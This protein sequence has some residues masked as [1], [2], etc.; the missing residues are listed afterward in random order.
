MKAPSLLFL[1]LFIANHG[2]AQIASTAGFIPAGNFNVYYQQQG[3]GP[4]VVLLHAGLQNSTMWESQITALSKTHRV[5][6]IDLP[7]HGRTKGIDTTLLA[8]EVVKIV[9]DSLGLQKLSLVGLSM[10]ASVAQD[11]VI[12]Y[13]GRV[14]KL[15]LL[16]SGINGYERHFPIDSASTVWYIRYAKAME[17]KD[18]V[19]AAKEFALAWGEGIHHK[20]ELTKRAAQNVYRTTLQTLRT[21]PPGWPKLQMAPPAYEVIGNIRVP[22]LIIHGDE[23]LTYIGTACWYLEKT[24][25]GAKR[26]MLKGAAHM[27]NL[28][29]PDTVNKLLVDFLR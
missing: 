18:T 17:E 28:E 12:A 4:A 23:D 3:T 24:I 15:V 2:H 11:F 8:S 13:P 29:Q 9:A 26:V 21:K 22:T 6:A 20:G 16:A 14:N 5:V 19:T 27:L 7:F 10:G 25:H 1:F